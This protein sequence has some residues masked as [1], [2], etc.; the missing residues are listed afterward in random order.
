MYNFLTLIM[1]NTYTTLV[2]YQVPC[3]VTK[4]HVYSTKRSILIV[5]AKA[6]HNGYIIWSG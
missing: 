2:I 4:R 5:L 6:I 3:S 1:A